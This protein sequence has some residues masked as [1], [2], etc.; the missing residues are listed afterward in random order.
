MKLLQQR[1]VCKLFMRLR[2]FF[3]NATLPT[4]HGL[5][6]DGIVGPITAQRVLDL[7][8]NDGY[9]DNGLPASAY[10]KMYK[11]RN[12]QAAQPSQRRFLANC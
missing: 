10:G 8:S 1:A 11:V 5:S 6:V 9:V 7:L 12:P 2:L 3:Q 4:E